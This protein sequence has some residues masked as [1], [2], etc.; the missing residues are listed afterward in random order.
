MN[1]E[2]QKFLRGDD[3]TD[4]DR[5]TQAGYRASLLYDEDQNP[6]PR[7]SSAWRD[8]NRGWLAA[9]NNEDCPIA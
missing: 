3:L 8:W 5:A 7:E 6:F 9:A 1:N 2:T 4:M